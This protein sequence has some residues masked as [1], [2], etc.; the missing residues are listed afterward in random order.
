MSR[1]QFPSFFLTGHCSMYKK[2]EKLGLV[3]VRKHRPEMKIIN[4]VTID[5]L[6]CVFGCESGE[7]ERNQCICV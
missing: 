4:L 6:R 1:V 5:H 3:H 2:T 7:E